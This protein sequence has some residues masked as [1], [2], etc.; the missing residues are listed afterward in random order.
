MRHAFGFNS[1]AQTMSNFVRAKCLPRKSNPPRKPKSRPPHPAKREATRNFLSLLSVYFIVNTLVSIQNK[2]K[3]K[4]SHDRLQCVAKARR[5]DITPSFSSSPFSPFT[6]AV[7]TIAW[8]HLEN[9][10]EKNDGRTIGKG[11]FD[12]RQRTVFFRG[13]DDA[14]GRVLAPKS[15]LSPALNAKSATGSW[16][17]PLAAPPPHFIALITESIA[18]KRRLS[19]YNLNGKGARHQWRAVPLPT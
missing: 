1:F 15:A 18:G 3:N 12:C 7:N 19:D 8:N 16:C 2:P 9:E 14:P 11:V 4:R 6:Q 10:P 13:L 17:G 5:N